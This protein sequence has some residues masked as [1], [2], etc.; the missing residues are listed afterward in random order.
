MAYLAALLVAAIATVL[1][2]SLLSSL[3][4][5]NLIMV[6]LLGIV[7]VA[8]NFGRGPSILASLVSVACFDYFCIPPRYTFAVTDTQYILTF[9]IMLFIALLITGLTGEI[10]EQA[11]LAKEKERR[12]AALHAMSRELCLARSKDE[13]ISISLRH[14]RTFFD[15]IACIYLPSESGIL[16]DSDEIARQAF[17]SGTTIKSG[18][19]YFPLTGT[20]GILGVMQVSPAA[21]EAIEKQDTLTLLETFANQVAMCIEVAHLTEAG[22][23]ANLQIEQELLR[24]TLLSSISHDLRTPLA[25]ITGASDTLLV[26]RALLDAGKQKELLQV[27]HEESDRLNEL[28]SKL[29]DMTKLESGL[30]QINKS[31]LPLEEIVGAAI[32]RMDK[33]LGKHPLEIDLPVDLP[34]VEIDEILFQLVFQ[35]LIENAVKYTSSETPIKIKAYIIKKELLIEVSDQ[36]LGIKPGDEE[37]I[38]N[39]FFQSGKS[40]NGIGLGLAICRS[41]IAAHGGTITACNQLSGGALFSIRLPLTKTPPPT[42]LEDV[43]PS[44]KNTSG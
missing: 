38:F 8:S 7:Y 32:N 4:H 35:N 40:S 5:S 21:V 24:N 6:Y 11:N 13:I 43:Q 22:N 23:K 42:E 30:L 28:V 16:C 29:L 39:K 17:K 34:L 2:R 19:L 31:W 33:R 20:T 26:D 10:Q 27:I 12:T 41:I 36:G 3:D 9:V 1:N 15:A 18:S 37:Q 14:I 44:D 25:T